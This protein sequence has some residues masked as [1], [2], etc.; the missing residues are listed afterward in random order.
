MLPFHPLRP[1]ISVSQ[2]LFLLQQPHFRSAFSTSTSF[3]MRPQ[4]VPSALS[5][6][7]REYTLS[8][9]CIAHRS[10]CSQNPFLTDMVFLW[11]DNTY[12]HTTPAT[13][14]LGLISM[15][16]GLAC[17]AEASSLVPPSP[18]AIAMCFAAFRPR[19]NDGTAQCEP[20]ARSMS[21]CWFPSCATKLHN[22]HQVAF[23]DPRL[24]W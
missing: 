9:Q 21:L 3:H 1:P 5:M 20:S 2:F 13:R 15:T 14:V 4:H 24:T 23:A 11:L 16:G 7:S 18:C 22:S 6:W 10:W 12:L 17:L 19:C 8:P